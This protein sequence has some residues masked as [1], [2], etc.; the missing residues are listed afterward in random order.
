MQDIETPGCLT[1][2]RLRFLQEVCFQMRCMWPGAT[3]C[4]PESAFGS[5]SVAFSPPTPRKVVFA[6]AFCR[7]RLH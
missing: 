5:A 2:Q 7:R 3:R 6:V 1:V 4:Q